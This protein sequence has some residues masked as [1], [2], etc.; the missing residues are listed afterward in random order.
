[1]LFMAFL[2]VVGL[3]ACGDDNGDNLTM[4]AGT[5]W[6]GSHVV[7]TTTDEGG[8]TTHTAIIGLIF[9]ED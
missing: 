6:Y 1:M 7:I 8:E 5:E 4:I 2:S 3:T 9:S